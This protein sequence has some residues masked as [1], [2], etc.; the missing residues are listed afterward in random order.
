MPATDGDEPSDNIVMK[1]KAH[2]R[3]KRLPDDNISGLIKTDANT[4]TG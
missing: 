1:F 2:D 4:L 3:G